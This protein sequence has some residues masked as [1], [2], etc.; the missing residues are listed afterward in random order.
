MANKVVFNLF[1]S[2]NPA[3]ASYPVAIQRQLV[4]FAYLETFKPG[5]VIIK[6]GGAPERYYM[7]LSGQAL[8]GNCARLP[9]GNVQL[10]IRGV[11][12][13]GDDFGNENSIIIENAQG[14]RD[15]KFKSKFTTN[16]KS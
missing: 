5:K 11:I 7:V 6:E 1:S 15:S 10:K 14:Y 3:K 4:E 16:F 9:A 13:A 8:R 2:K 12:N